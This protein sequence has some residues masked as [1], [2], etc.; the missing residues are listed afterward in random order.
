MAKKKKIT[1]D[2]I[3]TIYMDYVIKNE[4]KP[5]DISDFCK[6]TKINEVDFLAHFTSLKKVEKA[7]YKELFLNS[8]DVLRESEE[9]TT[10]DNKN[11]LISLY[12]TFFENLTLNREFV[13]VSLKGCKNQV[14]SFST[15]SSLK[16]SFIHFINDL[17]L[18]ESSIPLEGLE[19]IQ[20]KFINQSLWFQLFLTIKFWLDDTSE[21]FEK[22]D[23][24]IEKSINTSFELLENKFLKNAFDLGKFVYKETFQKKSSVSH[25]KSQ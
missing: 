25:E 6:E 20:Q 17:K 18:S 19:N 9:F 14:Q 4:K 23:I 10:F 5:S 7:I 1:R 11:K 12:F 8:I 2:D 15:L 13:I 3:F 24:F 16:K 22:T 21:S